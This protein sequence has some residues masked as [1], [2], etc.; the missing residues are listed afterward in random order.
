MKHD[1]PSA[2]IYVTL[3]FILSTMSWDALSNLNNCMTWYNQFYSAYFNPFVIL[4]CKGKKILSFR[5]VIVP[6]NTK[7]QVYYVSFIM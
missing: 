6:V 3:A 4:V 5:I 2:V 1:S 7:Q